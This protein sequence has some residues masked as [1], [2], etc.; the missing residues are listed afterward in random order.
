MSK[1]LSRWHSTP[2]FGG[3]EKILLVFRCGLSQALAAPPASGGEHA[4]FL[5]AGVGWEDDREYHAL[6][7]QYQLLVFDRLYFYCL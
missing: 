6:L 7:E 3:T 4:L 2:A 1:G 5:L